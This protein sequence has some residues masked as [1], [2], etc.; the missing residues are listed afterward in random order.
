MGRKKKLPSI[1][2]SNS[3]AH[4]AKADVQ[5]AG[6]IA[7]SNVLETGGKSKKDD[8][9]LSGGDIIEPP[10]NPLSL[11]NAFEKSNSLRQNVDSYA[12]NIHG[13]GYR[14]VPVLDLD[15]DDADDQVREAILMERWY[16]REAE[17]I[18]QEG[19][20]FDADA[21]DLEDIP[22]PTDEEISKRKKSLKARMRREL[23]KL[24]TFFQLCGMDIPFTTL[25]IWKRQ[26]KEITGTG[27][28]EILRDQHDK[29]AR[30]VYAPSYAMRICKEIK[31]P[32]TVKEWF[33]VS[34]IKWEERYIQ[35][36]FR[37]FV[38]DN[39]GTKVYF[40]Q[41]GDPRII[42]KMTG[43]VYKDMKTFGTAKKKGNIDADDG[44][45]TEILYFPVHS[46]RSVYGI[47]RWI[48]ALL[49]VLGSRQ[50]EEVN[51]MYF[52]NRSIPP[53]ALLVSGGN[54]KKG[55]IGKIEKYIEDNMKGNKNFARILVIEAQGVKNA[56]DGKIG[57]PTMEFVPLINAQLQDALF[58]DYDER[59]IDK[60]GF[61][62]RLPRLLRGDAR[63]FNRSTADAAI[64][65]GEQQV[66]G[67]ERLEFDHVVNHTIVPS[68]GVHYYRFVSRNLQTSD[69]EAI[70]KM[71]KDTGEGLSANEERE[72]L[73]SVYGREF[74]PSSEWWSSI[75]RRAIQQGWAGPN[76]GQ[77][78][79]Q[80]GKPGQVPNPDGSGEEDAGS[81]TERM[82]RIN[83][84]R[85]KIMTEGYGA[86]TDELK[87]Q[88]EEA[89]LYI[90]EVDSEQMDTFVERDKKKGKGKK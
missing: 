33:P 50:S 76:A 19:P 1:E 6:E 87:Q 41:Y 83:E 30:L 74:K 53:L 85:D 38:M 8:V 32:V 77:M 11:V 12:T 71:L 44:P 67:P 7:Q 70:S 31:M 60:T 89:G 57:T 86:I 40:K 90:I 48:G 22:E 73:E 20:E 42:S 88:A 26:D 51:F 68:I 43:K 13:F 72:I 56:A 61:A 62:F 3:R 4:V 54:L 80:P 45:A 25:R 52:E 35:R 21:L 23:F 5:G 75:P 39:G 82:Q 55:Q 59:N 27:Y 63:D 29:P 47:P 79:G 14:F 69:P 81:L 2:A 28:L 36:R 49:S 66:F 16:E 10:Y 78:P 24:R 46:S 37:K 58:Q 15:A 18:E 84:L 9:L 17:L 64:R 34:P 65:F